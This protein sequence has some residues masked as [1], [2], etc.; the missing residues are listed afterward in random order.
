VVSSGCSQLDP[1]N[2][3][4]WTSQGLPRLQALALVPGLGDVTRDEIKMFAPWCTRE[5]MRGV[6]A[7]HQ[8]RAG[9]GSK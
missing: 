2:E 9:G 1:D 3:D 8:S 6:I 7:E 5:H 4:H